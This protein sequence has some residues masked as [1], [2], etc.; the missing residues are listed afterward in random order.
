METASSFGRDRITASAH[1][2]RNS[3]NSHLFN[4]DPVEIMREGDRQCVTAQ[5]TAV[6]T[7]QLTGGS[8]PISRPAPNRNAPQRR[9]K[10][11]TRRGSYRGGPKR[12]MYSRGRSLYA[13][14]DARPSKKGAEEKLDESKRQS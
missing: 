8:A 6:T 13:S 10:S 11:R 12:R 5:L 4:D 9:P 7:A 3:G 1:F 14:K 2:A